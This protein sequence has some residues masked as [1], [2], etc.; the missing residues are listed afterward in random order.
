MLNVEH[1]SRNHS[2]LMRLATAMLVVGIAAPIA[3]GDDQAKTISA[4]SPELEWGPCPEFMPQGCAIAVLHGDPASPGADVLF[5]LSGHT[6][7]PRHTHTS[8][9]RMV[10]I[11][12]EMK[13]HY[14][15]HEP[16][17]IAAG[18]YA[19]GPP[20]LAHDASCD[21]DEDCVLF[22]AFEEPVDAMLSE[23]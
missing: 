17:T 3:L 9:E 22:I 2:L 15:G 14:D 21:S 13:V 6:S 23:E 12:G 5:K 20:G 19:Y 16:K 7:V 11:A 10:L 18:D 1:L 4:D 8:A